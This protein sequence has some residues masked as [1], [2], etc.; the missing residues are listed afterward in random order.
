MAASLDRRAVISAST[1]CRSTSM[2]IAPAASFAFG[3]PMA[4]FRSPEKQLAL[5]SRCRGQFDQSRRRGVGKAG[6]GRRDKGHK[7]KATVGPT[8]DIAGDNL[9]LLRACKI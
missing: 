7:P 3:W 6:I 2:S 8:G 9:E 1:F 4:F 5:A